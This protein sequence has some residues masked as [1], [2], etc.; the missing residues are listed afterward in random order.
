[1]IGC[2]IVIVSTDRDLEIT[3]LVTYS[4][5]NQFFNLYE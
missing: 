3:D 1:M 2:D 5:F 4:K